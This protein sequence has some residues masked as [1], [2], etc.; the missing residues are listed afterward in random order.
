MRSAELF[1]ALPPALSLLPEEG[2]TKE[3]RGPPRRRE[4]EEDRGIERESHEGEREER[5]TGLE[6]REE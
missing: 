4:R 5:G 2:E 6:E 1:L 3:E